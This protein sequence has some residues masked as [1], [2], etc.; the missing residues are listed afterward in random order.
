MN[1]DMFLHDQSVGAIM[2]AL[3][4]SLMEQNDI[5]PMLKGMKFR[6]SEDGLVVLNPPLVKMTDDVQEE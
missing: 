4:K 2:M 1:K 5:V 3:Q 6:L